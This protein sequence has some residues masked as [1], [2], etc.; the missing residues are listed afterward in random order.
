MLKS[1]EEFLTTL[2][3]L[4]KKKSFLQTGPYGAQPFAPRQCSGFIATGFNRKAPK[5]FK[6]NTKDAAMRSF[7]S[8]ITSAPLQHHPPYLTF[9]TP[10]TDV[11][12]RVSGSFCKRS[13]SYP[14]TSHALLDKRDLLHVNLFSD[15]H[16]WKGVSLQSRISI[17]GRCSS[18]TQKEE[19]SKLAELK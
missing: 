1:G 9:I 18:V 8:R 7:S 12:W 11:I 17:N 5:I 13:P 16:I 6:S 15:K 14:S 4:K 10:S 19:G 2:L 3:F